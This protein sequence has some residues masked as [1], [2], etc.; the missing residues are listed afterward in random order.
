MIKNVFYIKIKDKEGE[1][2]RKTQAMYKIYSPEKEQ[3]Y[4]V[5]GIKIKV[6]V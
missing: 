3:Q 4:G 1:I 5:L 2:T 6:V